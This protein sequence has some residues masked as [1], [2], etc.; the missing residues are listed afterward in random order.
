MAG[1]FAATLGDYQY[2][3]GDDWITCDASIMDWMNQKSG[4]NK[5]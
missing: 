3:R 5:K 4:G 2:Y 1:Y